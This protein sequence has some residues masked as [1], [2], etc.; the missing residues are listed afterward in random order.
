MCIAPDKSGDR[1]LAAAPDQEPVQRPDRLLG[2]LSRS[3]LFTKT[4]PAAVVHVD[5]FALVVSPDGSFGELVGKKTDLLK[6]GVRDVERAELC[7]ETK[8]VQRGFGGP[9]QSAEF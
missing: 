2:C 5:E 7:M 1:K 6:H 9:I 4:S 8:L 3:M